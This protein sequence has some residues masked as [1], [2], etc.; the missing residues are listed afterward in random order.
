MDGLKCINFFI[1]VTQGIY[2]TKLGVN[3][4]IIMRFRWEF[5]LA[6]D[7]FWNCFHSKLKFHVKVSVGRCKVVIVKY[8]EN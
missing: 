7:Y 1:K 2:V 8:A 4:H 3:S 5:V 6:S